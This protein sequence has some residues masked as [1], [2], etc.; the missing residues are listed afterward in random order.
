V[1]K[2]YYL[3]V[4]AILLCSCS[5]ITLREGLSIDEKG[6]WLQSGRDAAKT[7]ISGSASILKPPFTK[8]WNFNSEAAFSKN[9]LAVC[10]GVLFA[11]CLSGDVYAIDMKNGSG[12]GKA[13][14]KSKSSFS[15]PVILKDIIVL[16]FSDGLV[17]Y[18]TGYDFKTGDY[19]WK[20]KIEQCNS[21]P[22]C[23]GEN[24][25]ICTVK[26]KIYKFNSED[27]KQIWSYKNETSFFTSPAI[28]N[29][30][31]L[32]GDTKGT[33]TAVD[34]NSGELK[35]KFKTNGGI[36]SDV[37]V[38]NDMIFFG[39]DDKYFYCLDTAGNLKW[40]KYLDTKFVS[41]SSF[42]SENVISTGING[43]VF[44][45]NINTGDSV[46]VMET[47]GTITASPVVHRDKIYVGSY[48][49][50]F[51]C[52]DA[53]SGEVLWK[54]EFDERIRTSAVIWKNFLIIACDDKSIYCFR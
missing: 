19:K 15:T 21:S 7:N 10:D 27:G 6:D 31:V 39:A 17:N 8:I 51:Y 16:T 43:K 33:L 28:C 50:F 4:L 12:I 35:W 52:L 22:A 11:G 48:D 40:K 54:N 44:S 37:S 41:S 25:F 2:N 20:R 9:S 53:N 45:L 47:N 49:K 1:N 18:I 34:K 42:Y 29:D 14:V 3:L 13:N 26:G 23:D 36:Y 38:Y 46:W 24:V 30:L 5:S 32:A